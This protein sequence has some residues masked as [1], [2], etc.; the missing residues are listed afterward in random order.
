MSATGPMLEPQQVQ[1]DDSIHLAEYWGVI[2]KHRRLIA[3][4]IA[5]AIVAGAVISLLTTSQYKAVAVL[6]VEREKASPFDVG[7]AMQGTSYDPEFLP[8][9]TRLIRSREIARRAAERLNLAGNAELNPPKTGWFAKPKKAQATGDADSRLLRA[10]EAVQKNIQTT[11]IRGTALVE[12]SFTSTSPKLAADIVNAV[13]DAYIDWNI[14][15]KYLVVGQATRFLGTQI[16]QLKSEIQQKERQLQAYGREKDIVSTNASENVTMQKLGTF[17]QDYAAAV[18]DR[19]A[20]EARYYQ[21]QNAKPETVADSLSGLVAQL[22]GEQARMEREYAE[23]LNLYKPEWPAMQQLRAQI[24]KGRQNLASVIQETVSKARDA[25]YNDYLT[26]ARREQSLK[27]VLQGQKSEA[28]AQNSNAVEYNNLKTEVETKRTLLDSLM[29]RQAETEVTSRLRGERVSNIRVVDRA[30]PPPSRFRPSYRKNG[31]LSLFLGAV[32]GIGLAFLLEYMDRSIRT[33]EQVEKIVRVP[34][35]GIIPS[36]GTGG[37]SMYGAYRRIYGSK[38]ERK[39]RAAD[40]ETPAI[41]MIP[42]THPRSTTAEA[43]RALRAAL[44]L[45]RAGGVKTFVVTSCLPGEGKTTTAVNTAVVLGQLGKRVL[46]VDADLHKPRLHEVLKV[47]NRVG[48]VSVLA[49]NLDAAAAIVRTAVPNVWAVPAG[50][51]SPNPSGLLSSDAMTHFLGAAAANFDFVVIDSP[52]VSPV[53][54]ALV[55]GSQTDGVVLCI[56][57]GATPRDLVLGTR[58]K[59]QRS[60]VRILGALINDLREDAMG[61]GRYYSYYARASEGYGETRPAGETKAV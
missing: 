37:S 4:C 25:A 26:A 10:A 13:A 47:S 33:I 17:N 55:L 14:E 3:G 50:P 6:N 53:A 11:P 16:E 34:A 56:K 31:M 8:T 41:E 52:P 38:P 18:G 48:L 43:Y 22:R 23:K 36:L 9:Q 46:L 39:I 60:N 1:P 30:L 61:Y 51:M 54:D 28:M 12:V 59:L 32:A 45:S 2:V 5:I 24:D 44:L 21:L 7:T 35:L 40:D 19:V 29:K 49:E 58:D 27:G 20:K 42:H 15:S 57:G